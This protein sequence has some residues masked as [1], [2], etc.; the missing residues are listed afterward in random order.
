MKIYCYIASNTTLVAITTANL[1]SVNEFQY[2]DSKRLIVD[3]R[4]KLNCRTPR[5]GSNEKWEEKTI[6]LRPLTK[7]IVGVVSIKRV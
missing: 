1:S 6:T 4:Y 3:G 5:Q 2:S 7:E